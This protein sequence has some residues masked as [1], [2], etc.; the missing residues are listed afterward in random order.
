MEAKISVS[1]GN[2]AQYQS[3]CD[4][5]R[6]TYTRLPNCLNEL[7]FG[8]YIEDWLMTQQERMAVI[9]LLERVKP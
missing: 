5:S 4:I 2:T 6:S 1:S 8:E 7:L 9:S 3:G